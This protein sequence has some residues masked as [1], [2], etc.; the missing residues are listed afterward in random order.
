M[1][2]ILLPDYSLREDNQLEGDETLELI[3]KSIKVNKYKNNVYKIE[4]DTNIKIPETHTSIDRIIS[5]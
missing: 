3:L 1:T 4:T 5:K 2:N